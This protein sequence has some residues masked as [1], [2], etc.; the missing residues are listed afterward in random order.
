MLF[1]LF[2][3]VVKLIVRGCILPIYDLLIYHCIIP[4][5]RG[6]ENLDI[7]FVIRVGKG[8]STIS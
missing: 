3:S 1:D 7:D 6:I 4:G 2:H 5:G 8:R